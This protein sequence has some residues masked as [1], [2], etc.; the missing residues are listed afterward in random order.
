LHAVTLPVDDRCLAPAGEGALR[1]ALVAVDAQAWIGLGVSRSPFFRVEVRPHDGGLEDEGAAPRH[2]P[3]RE[4]ARQ[5]PRNRS[6]A[7]ALVRGARAVDAQ[8]APLASA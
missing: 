4:E 7:R 5:A 3:G 8:T 1:A 2:A 6:L